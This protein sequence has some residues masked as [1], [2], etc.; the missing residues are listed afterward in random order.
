MNVLATVDNGM[1]IYITP[2]TYRI[3]GFLYY[4]DPILMLVAAVTVRAVSFVS[5]KVT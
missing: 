5:F 1:S 3:N 4:A 2:G